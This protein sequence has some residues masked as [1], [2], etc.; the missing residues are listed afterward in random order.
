MNICIKKYF[1]L[2][3]PVN[4]MAVLHVTDNICNKVFAHLY[5][6]RKMSSNT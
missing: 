3:C 2:F 5:I 6:E 1:I 4:I